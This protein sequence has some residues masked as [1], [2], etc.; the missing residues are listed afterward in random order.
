MRLELLEINFLH[1]K[2]Y[3]NVSVT[4]AI[5]LIAFNLQFNIELFIIFVSCI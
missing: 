3:W 4:S 5:F 1:V 2:L